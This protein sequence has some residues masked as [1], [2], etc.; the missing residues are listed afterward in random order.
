MCD[1]IQKFADRESIYN[2][3]D[4]YM[5]EISLSKEEIIQRI[6]IRFNLTEEDA[7]SYCDEVLEQ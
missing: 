6:M 2:V 5:E 1:K 7:E 3:I 4:V